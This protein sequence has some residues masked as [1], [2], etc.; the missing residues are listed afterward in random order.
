VIWPPRSQLRRK[1]WYTALFAASI[2][3][4]SVPHAPHAGVAADDTPP[5]VTYTID[6]IPGTNN[7]YRGSTHGN[8]IV[9]HWSVSDPES[10]IISTSGCDPA[11]QILGP[12]PAPGTTRTC[13]ATSAGGT[14]SITTKL[15]KIDAD[16]PA[17]AAI[18][19]RLP[20]GAGWYRTPVGISWNGTDATSGIAGCR[21]TLNYAGPD[22]TGTTVVGNCT[23][24]A[25]NASSAAISLRYDSTPPVTDAVSAPAPNAAG[26]FRSPLSIGWSG[27]DITSGIASCRASLTYSGPD[28]TGKMVSGSCTDNA[29]NSAAGAVLV[30][31]D[32][33]PPSLR[34]L[35]L[36]ALDGKV[37]LHW[38][39]SGAASLR[40]TRSPGMKRAAS[41][42]VYGGN[43]S[44]FADNSVENYV[45]YRYTLSATDAAGNTAAR[46]ISAIPLPVLYAPRPGARLGRI[47]SLLFAWKAAKKADYYNLQLWRGGHKIGSWWPSS[48]RLRLPSRWHSEG[49]TRRL[50]SGAYTWYVWPGRGARRLGKYGPI[51]GKSTFAV[52]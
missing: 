32:T 10:P 1:A 46:G 48:P 49:K 15:L 27:S 22:T 11:I 18:T 47:P 13:T 17:S 45:R 44:G 39:V 8:F 50:K 28:T 12:L 24:N 42:D 30:K 33:T 9:V 31:Y 3:P 7:W 16:P 20:N 6:G 43:G 5:V 35:S 51:V 52:R 37:R 25:G 14:T 29:G 36:R 26:W 19:N 23:D 41:S 38:K 4:L 21:P 34:S 40:L 2:V